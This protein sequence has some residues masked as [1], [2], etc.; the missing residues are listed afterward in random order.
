MYIGKITY[1]AR[2]YLQG[3]VFFRHF[4]KCAKYRPSPIPRCSC[5]TRNKLAIPYYGGF[6]L[7]FSPIADF[8]WIPILRIAIFSVGPPFAAKRL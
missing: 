2:K 5:K 1:L 7:S 4:S 8:S 6:G 3:R